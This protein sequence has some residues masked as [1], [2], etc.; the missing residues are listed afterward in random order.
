MEDV[1]VGIWVEHIAETRQWEVQ[2]IHHGGFN[3]VGCSSKD[4]TSHKISPE[5]QRCIFEHPK[6]DA[7]CP[8]TPPQD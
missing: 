7:C 4:I 2:Y 5:R 6:E 1:A 3:P 8:L